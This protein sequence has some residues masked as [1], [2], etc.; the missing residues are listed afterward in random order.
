MDFIILFLTWIGDNT[1]ISNVSD[2]TLTANNIVLYNIRHI[3]Y[4]QK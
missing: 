1:N 4:A 2:D 3:L